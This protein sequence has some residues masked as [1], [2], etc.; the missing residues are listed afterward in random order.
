MPT[1]TDRATYGFIE[2]YAN[3]NGGNAPSYAAVAD[4][5]LGFEYIPEVTDSYTWLS[6][7]IKGQSAKRE[8]MRVFETG[9]FERQ[10]NDLDGNEF[11]E[12]WLPSVLDSV[13]VRTRVRESIG[14]N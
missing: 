12:S 1:D 14:T 3:D 13:K 6:K 8:I 5:V 4:G 7:R 9:E 2:E 10:L 11:V